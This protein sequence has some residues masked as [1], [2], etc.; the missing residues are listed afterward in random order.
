MI[1]AASELAAAVTLRRARRDDCEAIWRWNFAPE[2]RARSRRA[3]AVAF[4]EHERW[5]VRRLADAEA[6]IWVI[7]ED[8]QPVGV[9]RLDPPGPGGRGRARISIALAATARGRGL[10]KAAIAA[11]CRAWHGPIIA[12]IFADN[13]ASWSCFEACGFRAAG[14]D[15]DLLTYHWD[16]ET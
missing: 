6:P 1:A 5:F 15:D 3:E 2:V 7:D 10:G 11:A 14:T 12:E 8:H 13:R 16:P 4:A 9:V